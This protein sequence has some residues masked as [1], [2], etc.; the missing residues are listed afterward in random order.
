MSF[1][2][3]FGLTSLR[4]PREKGEPKKKTEKEHKNVRTH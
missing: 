1:T 4:L 2:G 3:L